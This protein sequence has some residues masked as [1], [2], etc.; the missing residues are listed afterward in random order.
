MDQPRARQVGGPQGPGGIIGGHDLLVQ[1]MA[2]CRRAPPE[3]PDR[4][5]DGARVARPVQVLDR[6]EVG[7]DIRRRVGELGPQDIRVGLQSLIGVNGQ[8]P[9][10]C[11]V[12]Q[13]GVPGR[14]EG[15]L[16]FPF[17]YRGTGLAGD[18]Q[19]AVVRAGVVDHN[20]VDGVPDRFQA[21]A[22]H[23][24][25]VLHDQAGRHQDAFTQRVGTPLCLEPNTVLDLGDLPVDVVGIERSMTVVVDERTMRNEQPELA[26][27]QSSAQV[28]VLESTDLEPLVETSESPERRGTHR[29]TESDEPPCL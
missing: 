25:L 24:L 22:Q 13:C 29:E 4:G 10:P 19:R 16:P 12:Q 14:C 7:L 21:G 27:V 15:I 8:H 3:H 20:L 9:L 17:H 18:L 1:P 23:L 11:G 26:L 5:V 28:V 2:P 6:D